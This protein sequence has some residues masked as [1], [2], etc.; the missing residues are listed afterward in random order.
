MTQLHDDSPDWERPLTALEILSA[1]KVLNDIFV[2]LQEAFNPETPI[3]I[4]PKD[5]LSHQRFAEVIPK[6]GEENS[7]EFFFPQEILT[8]LLLDHFK[9][10]LLH[11]DNFP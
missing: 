3:F 1:S 2:K 9:N 10:S 5:A 4:G 6:E 7:I 8:K 11:D